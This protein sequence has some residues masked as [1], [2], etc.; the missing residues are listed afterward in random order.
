LTAHALPGTKGRRTVATISALALCAGCTP[1]LKLAGP[2]PPLILTP[3][4]SAGSHDGRARFREI[5][6]ALLDVRD[7][8]EAEGCDRW[9]RRLE[10]EAPATGLPVATAPSTARL[11][12]RIVP[13]IFGECAERQAT[14]FLDAIQPRDGSGYSMAD[15]GYDVAAFRVSG[16]SSSASNAEEIRAQIKA[17]NLKPGEKLVLVGHSKGMS[18][19]IE[20]LAGDR[21]M[22]PPGSAIV[23]LSGVVAGT[24]I[25]DFGDS[26]YKRIAWI[27]VPG[28]PVG[29]QGGV[30][31]LTRRH[32][33][34]FLAQHPLPEDLHYYSIAAF[35]GQ[36]RIS[37]GLRATHAMLSQ[38]DERNDGN[39]LFHDSILPRSKIL[40]Y[41]DAD[42]WAVAM[43]FETYAPRWAAVF[44]SRNRFPRV[45][46]LEAIART[47]EEDFPGG[48]D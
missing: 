15:L 35:T 13:G 32:R 21:S 46:L 36:T 6:C 18:D 41:P 26:A 45:V 2:T 20:M 28:C 40:A 25:A 9:L 14:P 8:T 23:S 24:P 44:A 37:S 31:S 39:V 1:S 5:F 33:L 27:P 7:G 22:V 30:T 19:I 17:M 42:H 11:R 3:A 16:R 38:I 48:S 4:V 12:L 29:D 10:G 47:I 34:N 43:P